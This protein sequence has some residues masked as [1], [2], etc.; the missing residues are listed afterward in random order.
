MGNDLPVA[1]SNVDMTLRERAR[2]TPL[3]STIS[4]KNAD[5]VRLLS[6]GWFPQ[7]RIGKEARGQVIVLGVDHDDELFIFPEYGVVS[8]FMKKIVG[9]GQIVIMPEYHVVHV[10]EHIDVVKPYLQGCSVHGI[11]VK[12]G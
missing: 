12:V 2:T 9:F 3:S 4:C 5:F 6:P 8:G 7:K 10:A 1:L 11:W